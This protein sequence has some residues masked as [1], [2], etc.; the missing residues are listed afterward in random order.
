MSELGVIGGVCTAH[1]P[2]LWT[3]PDSEDPEVVGRVKTLLGGIGEK[4][5]SMKPDICIVIAN[6]HA[7]QFLL[8]CTAS[9]TMHMGKVASGAFAGRDYSFQVASD[10]SLA[11]IRHAQRNGFDPGFTSN[12]TLDYAFGIPMDFTGMGSVPVVPIFVNAYVPP[13]PSMERCFA[14]GRALGDGVKALGLRAVVVCSGGL[15]HYPGTARYRDPGPDTT[16]D[17]HF[18]DMMAGGELRYLLALDDRKLD[19]TGNIELR[20]WGVAAGMIGDR[21]PDLTNFEP[22]WHHNYGTV[23]WTTEPAVEDFTP[24]YPPVHPDRVRLSETLHS[25]AANESERTRYLADP[26][27][28]AASIDG[29]TEIERDALVS[30][31]Q[32]RMIE[33]GMHPFVPH[34]YRRVLERAGILTADAPEKT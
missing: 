8:H 6:D 31:D 26:A 33:I 27:A 25:L 2:Q 9:F 14:F 34:A 22:T 1:A 30:L 32:A 12:A 3:L 21:A 28:Y 10:A 11:L 29:L 4:L 16:F 24:H 7:S 18:M 5:R 23:A 17:R 19:E 20:C 13:Q 15:S